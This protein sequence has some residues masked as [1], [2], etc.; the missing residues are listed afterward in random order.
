MEYKASL[1]KIRVELIVLCLPPVLLFYG[2][3]SL[4]ISYSF[5]DALFPLVVGC[6]SS[7]LPAY[8]YNRSNVDL[9]FH[10]K[11]I[12][13]NKFY[14]LG[15]EG[16]IEWNN[17]KSANSRVVKMFK[18]VEI[19][20]SPEYLNNREASSQKPPIF[21]LK[22]KIIIYTDALTISNAEL[23]KRINQRK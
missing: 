6:I 9:S 22:S 23:A 14:T 8:I 15:F 16:F 4:A 13:S 21:F 3:V 18:Y 12:K 19:E 7:L 17:I 2:A 10:E 5:V 20:I 11:G 1:K